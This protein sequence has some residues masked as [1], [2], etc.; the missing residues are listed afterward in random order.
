MES[1]GSLVPTLRAAL[2]TNSFNFSH[3]DRFGTFL[4]FQFL[5]S[6][7]PRGH[8][9]RPA[10]RVAAFSKDQGREELYNGVNEY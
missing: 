1:S 5:F 6:I 2:S 10:S 4:H 9:G 8:Q 7:L 3:R